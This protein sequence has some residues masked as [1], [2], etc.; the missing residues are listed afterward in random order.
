MSTDLGVFALL[1][2]MAIKAN[3]DKAYGV[4]IRQAVA[5][6]RDRD[7]SSGAIY[8]T[9]VRLQRRGLVRSWDGDPKESLGG[10]ARR[11][12]RLTSAGEAAVRSNYEALQALSRKL[13]WLTAGH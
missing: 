13:R 4:T 9:L 7:V 10:R 8:T 1:V 2:L 12:Y 6:G 11:Y 3:G 5:A